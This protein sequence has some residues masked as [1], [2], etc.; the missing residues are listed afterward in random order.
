MCLH[1]AIR[2]GQAFL[3]FFQND[4]VGATLLNTST[5]Y[6][7]A[8]VYSY[9]LRL[10]LVYLNGYIDGQK[11]SADPFQGSGKT[12]L[13]IGMI[14]PAERWSFDGKI[15]QV[16]FIYRAKTSTEILDDATLVVHYSF[17][18]NL[19]NSGPM[20]IKQLNL[21]AIHLMFKRQ[22]LLCLVLLIY[23]IQSLFGSTLIQR[24]V[25]VLFIYRRKQYHLLGVYHYLVSLHQD[26]LLLNSIMAQ[27]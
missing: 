26:Q 16:S 3:G 7:I 23:H 17:N 14:L 6:H 11:Y 24:E 22:V 13:T 18:S 12:A 8:F 2:Y 20:Q 1:A 15:D 4:C 10:Q 25:G 5:W 21:Q 9:E 19:L 27:A